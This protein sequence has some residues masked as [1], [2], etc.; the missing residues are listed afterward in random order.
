MEKD[1]LKANRW[2][3]FDEAEK[4]LIQGVLAA[5]ALSITES[6]MSDLTREEREGEVAGVYVAGII[7]AGIDAHDG[8]EHPSQQ[9][10]MSACLALEAGETA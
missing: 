8:R 3:A 5:Y 1:E 10:I 6:D 9:Q 4:A 7:L 2:Q